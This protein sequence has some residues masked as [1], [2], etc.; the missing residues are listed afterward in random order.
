[1]EKLRWPTPCIK[2]TYSIRIIIYEGKAILLHIL[3]TRLPLKGD[4]F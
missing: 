2:T 4:M 3:L 1:M